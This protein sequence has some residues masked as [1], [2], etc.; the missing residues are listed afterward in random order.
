MCL[1]GLQNALKDDVDDVGAVAGAALS[2]AVNPLTRLFPDSA[3]GVLH[4][5]ATLLP[6]LDDLTPAASTF[7]PLVVQ[8]LTTPQISDQFR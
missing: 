6:D 7:V 3:V 1:D 5:L 4:T 2:L 8:L